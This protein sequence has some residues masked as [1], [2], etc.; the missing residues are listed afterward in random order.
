MG[1]LASALASPSPSPGENARALLL[2]RHGETQ[3]N[4]ERRY[5]G[6]LDSPLT[7]RGIAEAEAIGRRL[8]GLLNLRRRPSSLARLA[9]RAELRKSSAPIAGAPYSRQTIG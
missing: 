1:G 9:G 2:V 5:Q 3:W 8:A 7:E 4:V 6:Q